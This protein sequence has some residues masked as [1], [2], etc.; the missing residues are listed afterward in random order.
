MRHYALIYVSFVVLAG[1]AYML[2][3][4]WGILSSPRMGIPSISRTMADNLPLDACY[5]TLIF[6]SGQ[7]R[8]AASVVQRKKF[9]ATKTLIALTDASLVTGVLQILFLCLVTLVTLDYDDTSH[10]AVACTAVM[11]T[12]LHETL[13]FARR[14]VRVTATGRTWTFVQKL[15]IARIFFNAFCILFLGGLCTA[16][17]IVTTSNAHNYAALNACLMEYAIFFFIIYLAVFQ[18]SDFAPG[19]ETVKCAS[20]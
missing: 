9:R 20:A 5:F 16:Y 17:V 4:I 1:L 12:F 14:K 15:Q 2:L 10:Y 6:M 19:W 8:L 13:M 3:L 7:G 18:T 11:V